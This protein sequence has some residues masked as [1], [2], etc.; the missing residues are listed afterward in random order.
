MNPR[1]PVPI[2][3]CVHLRGAPRFATALTTFGD[4]GRKLSETKAARSVCRHRSGF[5]RVLRV[6]KDRC[7]AAAILKEHRPS[8][9]RPAA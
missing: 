4:F 6:M 7:R 2:F 9:I 3:Q 1:C 8:L 5:S